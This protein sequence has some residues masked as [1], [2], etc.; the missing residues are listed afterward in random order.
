MQMHFE[1]YFTVLCIKTEHHYA[2]N[3]VA[4]GG[5]G[6]GGGERAHAFVRAC[7]RVCGLFLP[8]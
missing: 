4:G 7:V 3:N 5:G 6:G 1:S 8:A 2:D